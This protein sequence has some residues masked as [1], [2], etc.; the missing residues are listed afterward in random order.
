MISALGTSAEACEIVIWYLSHEKKDSY[1]NFV[2][3][4]T[5]H[6]MCLITS[7]TFLML[8]VTLFFLLEIARYHLMQRIYPS[9]VQIMHVFIL[10]HL[11]S[12]PSSFSE[13]QKVNFTFMHFSMC[14]VLS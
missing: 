1:R 12:N 8:I 11:L 4:F 3:P 5:T 13:Q 6:D 10:A 14:F 2:M 7:A 9:V